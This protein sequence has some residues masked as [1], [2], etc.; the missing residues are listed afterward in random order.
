MHQPP[1]SEPIDV[2][3]LWRD[4]PSES[5][6]V[7]S[8]EH[9][10]R[11]AKRL[12]AITLSEILMAGSAAVFF[13]AI[14]VWRLG[15]NQIAMAS[16]ALIAAWLGITFLML[17]RRVSGSESTTFAA[18][19]VEFYCREL[20]QRRKHLRSAWVWHGPLLLACMAM[21]A[22]V[23]GTGPFAYKRLGQVS[24]LLVALAVWTV[25]SMWHR[26]READAIQREL[27]EMR[28]ATRDE[29]E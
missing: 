27:K 1:N 26:F 10:L 15:W 8:P 13:A 23:I 2:K 21:A 22:V 25:F 24:P 5:V 3:A 9:L 7:V 19:G 20:E 4:Q 29:G 12:H 11:T 17:R 14:L 28:E 18:S 16:V 6:S